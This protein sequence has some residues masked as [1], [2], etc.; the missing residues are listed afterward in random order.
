MQLMQTGSGASGNQN[1]SLNA[2]K[3]CHVG[4]NAYNTL[5][6]ISNNHIHDNE[7]GIKINNNCNTNLSGN[8]FAINWGQTQQVLDN[9]YYE[10]YF[11]SGSFPWNFQ[12]NVVVDEDNAGNPTDP[13]VYYQPPSGG[14]QILDVRNN[15][16]GNSFNPAADFYGGVFYYLPIWCPPAVKSVS[17]NIDSAK[18]LY[19][20]AKADFDS[21]NYSVAKTS[22]MQVVNQYSITKFASAAM[23]D[24]FSLEQFENN[25][26]Q[27]LKNFY[28]TDSIIQNDTI[29]EDLSGFLAN[30]CNVQL[31]NWQSAID[32]Y[33]AIILNPETF[34][35]SVYAVIDLGQLYILMQNSN[36]REVAQGKILELIPVSKMGFINN[37]NYLLSLLPEKKTT[38]QDLPENTMLKAGELLQNQPNP[39]SGK[40][41]I[42]YKVRK[43]GFVKIKVVSQ[44]GSIVK[45]FEFEKDA[46]IHSVELNL[47][48]LS[49]GIYFYSLEING[50]RVDTK[51]MV[52]VK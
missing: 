8:P 32:H 16:W 33:E 19:M 4:I 27:W 17:V 1:I 50:I 15:C 6:K 37:R 47:Q 41:T 21:A 51:K 40:T 9:D 5:S 20:H 48:D 44:N 49:N 35:D 10:L 39:F 23:K 42:Q 12:Y 34:E 36:S 26:Y 18:A 11:S 7:Y 22:F 25:N 24:L 43:E 13:M 14:G 52:L 46:G 3:N 45:S 38:N 29:L 28:K 30:K 31:Q 2:I